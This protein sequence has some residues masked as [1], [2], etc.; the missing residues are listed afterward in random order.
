MDEIRKRVQALSPEDQKRAVELLR[1]MTPEQRKSVSERLLSS[2]VTVNADTSPIDIRESDEVRRMH[3]YYGTSGPSEIERRAAAAG[4]VSRGEGA[5]W[6]GV[7]S[8]GLTEKDQLDAIRLGLRERY[9]KDVPV[10]KNAETGEI[11][12]YN[13]KSN[14]FEFANPVGFDL[15]DV[16]SLAGPALVMGG[17]VLGAT[18][19]F[20][21][22]RGSPAAGVAG[23]I[24]GAG[25]GEAARLTIGRGF[26]INQSL[27]DA[28]ITKEALKESGLSLLG[29]WGARAIQALVKGIDNLVSGRFIPKGTADQLK[30]TLASGSADDVQAVIEEINRVTGGKFQPT[31][32]QRADIPSML[33]AEAQFAG[34]SG[35]GYVNQFRQL[36]R[37]N[38][39][40][41]KEYLDKQK[42]RFDVPT[43]G[44]FDVGQRV[45]SVAEGQ[46][47]PRRKTLSANVEKTKT[48]AEA[49]VEQ[50]PGGSASD[51]GAATRSAI[52]SEQEAFRVAKDAKYAEVDRL[53]AELNVQVKNVNTHKTISGIDKETK[54]SLFPSLSSQDKIL[55]GGSK[56]LDPDA[57]IGFSEL[58]QAIQ[59]LRARVRA[60]STGLSTE[61]N[62]KTVKRVLAALEKDRAEAL[63]QNPALGEAMDKADEFYRAEK[64][65]L[66][67]GI[68]GRIMSAKEG[69]FAINQEDVFRTFFKPGANTE[70]IQVF[71][72]VKDHPDALLAIRKAIY[73]E[74]KDKVAPDGIVNPKLHAKFVK[75]HKDV[76]RPFFSDKDFADI[77][78]SG[79]FGRVFES[80]ES[81][82]KIILDRLKRSFPGK[83]ESLD[84]QKIVSTVYTPDNIMGVRELKNLLKDSPETLKAVQAQV[85]KEMERKITSEGVLSYR[86][87]DDHITEY[88]GTIKE[89]YGPEYAKNLG[90]LR[91]AL[92]I[93][94]RKGSAGSVPAGNALTDIVR[95]YTGMFTTEGRFITAANRIR[96]KAANRAL[97]N[98]LQNPDDLKELLKLRSLSPGTKQAAV[99]LGQLG[100]IE[101]ADE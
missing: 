34:T 85:H 79:Q 10:R 29:A 22:G 100:A 98:A 80:I 32:A 15:G 48:A 89:L 94:G 5:P 75:D 11:E 93:A 44:P 27:S 87:L 41:L 16:K 31:L 17:D 68:V 28:D 99:I 90:I 78:K 64:D 56:V 25:V 82:Q 35:L 12:F 18:G 74:Y 97:V 96:G 24:A 9:G 73:Q 26:G 95:A 46:L 43:E 77:E 1:G 54:G 37:G 66:D 19:G 39:T 101:M 69:M 51:A 72:A 63:K 47:G 36:Y 6:R 21:L 59:Q 67:R 14:R 62:I 81:R 92:K 55:I 61:P 70:S 30:E 60:S 52:A 49:N 84:P 23:G 71:N 57:K 8:L 33:N 4:V 40:A 91:D 76:M 88:G 42:I 86:K 45:K 3:E 65:R 13:E 20:M 50:L 83:I 7:A 53:A 2:G 38:E 58:Q